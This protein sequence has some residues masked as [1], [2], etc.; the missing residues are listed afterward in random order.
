MLHNEAQAKYMM[1]KKTLMML[2]RIE[3]DDSGGV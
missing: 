2:K 3:Q 1:L